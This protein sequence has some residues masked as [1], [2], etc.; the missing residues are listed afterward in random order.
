MVND[1]VG[2]LTVAYNLLTGALFVPIIGALFW[3]RATGAG[4]LV[5]MLASSVVV[6]TL[7]ATRGLFSD[8]PIVYG[9][10][11]SLVV[12]VVVSLLTRRDAG[13]ESAEDWER[14]LQS[15]PQ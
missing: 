3:R 8:D 12:F 5:S 2:A 14:R 13:R 7:M 10:L 15:P 4:A 11:T 9:M 1:V 6:V